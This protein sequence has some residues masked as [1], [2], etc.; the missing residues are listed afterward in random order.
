MISGKPH[1]ALLH[2]NGMLMAEPKPKAP[3]SSGPS[4]PHF[5]DEKAD[6]QRGGGPLECL[7]F[8]FI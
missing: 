7:G 5:A 1:T 6:A 3:H 2:Q 4:D 8:S